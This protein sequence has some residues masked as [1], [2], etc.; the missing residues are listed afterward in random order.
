M[1]DQLLNGLLPVLNEAT[2]AAVLPEK[3]KQIQVQLLGNAKA[4]RP[5]AIIGD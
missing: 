3:L 1:E 5:R 4:A 2:K